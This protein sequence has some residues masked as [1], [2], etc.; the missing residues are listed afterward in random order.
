M[1]TDKSE[2]ATLYPK[3]IL[4]INWFNASEALLKEGYKIWATTY[5]KVRNNIIV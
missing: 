1:E 2:P 3:E 5:D 4:E